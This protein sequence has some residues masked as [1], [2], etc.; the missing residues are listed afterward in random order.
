MANVRPLEERKEHFFERINSMPHTYKIV[1]EYVNDR[2][3]IK[4]ECEIHGVW[5]TTPNGLVRG[6]GCPKC[7]KVSMGLKE[8][9]TQKEFEKEIKDRYPQ[10]KILSQI[11]GTNRNVTC[12]CTKHD[13][14]YE[15][16]PNK[17]RE[18]CGCPECKKE[19]KREIL[20]FADNF[21]NHVKESN[22][23][24]EII[25]EYID[26]KT[27]IK[28]RC[29]K[30]GYEWNSLPTVL[31]RYRNCPLCKNQVVV[32][33][34][35]DI[36]TTNPE[37]IP[38][39]NNIED[40]YSHCTINTTRVDFKCPTC[41]N[42]TNR[43]LR[44]T[45]IKG[46]HC[47]FCDKGVSLPNRVIRNLL[48][49]LTDNNFEYEYSPEWAG[50]YSY[51]A[52]FEK[53]GRAYIVEMDG[54]LHFKM[55]ATFQDKPDR[56]EKAQE[57]DRLKD[58]LA[59]EHNITMIRIKCVPET[60]ENIIKQIKESS[61]ADIF[62]LENVN[63]RES[64]Y[65]DN[66]LLKEICDK[67]N[68]MKC[69][70]AKNLSVELGMWVDTVRSFLKCGAELGLCNYDVTKTRIGNKNNVAIKRINVETGEEKIYDSI[71]KMR[72]DIY[73]KGDTIQYI[74]LMKHIKSKEPF[75]GYLYE[76]VS[77]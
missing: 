30:C 47:S 72:E 7:G 56:L 36:A 69:K 4:C 57:R 16:T 11:N 2:T 18:N 45:V 49:R 75:R 28:C 51:D 67:Y 50:K 20:G 31:Y 76:K 5:E 41:G 70:S 27:P 44:D 26:T 48:K 52:Y 15:R 10:I 22:P 33:G 74:T 37:L 40:A 46:F 55:S 8:R 68:L 6:Y 42:I 60:L 29:K 73:S 21:I 63:I 14:L 54:G 1:G 66:T 65:Y 32:K 19:K 24:I 71:E 58:R 35:N 62:D 23:H 17:L 12:L 38:Y 25:G 39:F 61:L 3:P 43:V 59:Q 64:F 9:K 34:K 77:A 53:N 13:Y